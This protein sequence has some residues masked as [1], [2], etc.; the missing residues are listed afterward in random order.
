MMCT[1]VSFINCS[2]VNMSFTFVS[3]VEMYDHALCHVNQESNLSFEFVHQL[4]AAL[5]TRRSQTND[6]VAFFNLQPIEIRRYKL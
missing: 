3:S 6:N 2:L 1:C 4:Y 5:M